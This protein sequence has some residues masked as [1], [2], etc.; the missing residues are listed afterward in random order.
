MQSGD[1]ENHSPDSI[2]RSPLE[3]SAIA[4]L[5]EDEGLSVRGAFHPQTGDAA[6]PFS[7]GRSVAT[8]FLIGNEGP[9]MWPLFSASKEAKDHLPHPLDRFSRRIVSKLAARLDALA[10][11]PFDG[12]PWLPFQRW[13][14]K[15]GPLFASPIGPLIHPVFGLWHAFRGALG[16][17]RRIDLPAAE[18]QAGADAAVDDG[19]PCRRCIEQPCLKSC[20]AEA[21][22]FARYDADRCTRHLRSEAGAPCVASGCLARRACP[23]GK[24]FAYSP[25][26]SEF[27]TRAFL[28]AAPPSRSEPSH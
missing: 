22:A 23:V 24:A 15:A 1:N 28:A 25:A 16:F 2:N 27:H 5:I 9:K 3:Y 6:P 26:Q 7:D 17:H 10:L 20:P 14:Q 21:F 19:G 11:F 12:P 4:S 8:L 13:A 18:F